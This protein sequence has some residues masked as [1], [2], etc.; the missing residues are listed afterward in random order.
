ML[1]NNKFIEKYE[2]Q[3]RDEAIA[4]RDKLNGWSK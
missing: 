1:K 4:L 3:D 2:Q